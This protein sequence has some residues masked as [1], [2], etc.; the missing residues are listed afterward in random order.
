MFDFI[1]NADHVRVYT[2]ELQDYHRRDN[3]LMVTSLIT[4][5]TIIT[6]SLE[7]LVTF[8]QSSLHVVS[9]TSLIRG[10]SCKRYT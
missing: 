3:R 10:V 8:V 7:Q 4:V 5:P 9:N 6:R 1:F 2:L